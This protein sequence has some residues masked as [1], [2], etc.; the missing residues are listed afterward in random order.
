MDFAERAASEWAL[1]YP[2]LDSSHILVVGRILRIAAAV[3]AGSEVDLAPHGLTRGEFDVLCALRRSGRPLRPG[4]ITTVTG[5]SPAAITKRLDRLAR[6]GLAG[7]VPSER[8]GRVVHVSLTRAGDDLVDE[9]FPAHVAREA[10]ALDGL[11][12]SERDQLGVLLARVLARLDP[13][14]Y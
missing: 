3:T 9:I 1:R 10:V 4:E 14:E 7:R 5:A 13:L 2:D 6:A 8:D 11:E 12:D